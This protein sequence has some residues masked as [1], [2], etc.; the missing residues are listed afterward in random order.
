[1]VLKTISQGSLPFFP[2]RKA[3]L[4]LEYM[5]KTIRLKSL[6]FCFK[7]QCSPDL[8]T[9]TH[10][11]LICVLQPF[12]FQL[13]RLL[14]ITL[15]FFWLFNMI[16]CCAAVEISYLLVLIAQTLMSN[17]G[18]PPKCW[19]N[20]SSRYF[21]VGVLALANYGDRKRCWMAVLVSRP[22]KLWLHKLCEH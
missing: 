15:I 11:L 9:P 1:M 4:N 13:P 5:W 14:W 17:H 6:S 3:F 21:V 2:V 10:C 20:S 7:H 8:Y 22:P 12:G 16:I 18:N 19:I